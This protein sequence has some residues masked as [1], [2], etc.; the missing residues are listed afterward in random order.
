MNN[1]EQNDYSQD[2]WITKLG[3]IVNS[4]SEDLVMKSILY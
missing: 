4:V 1:Q 2:L 3:E